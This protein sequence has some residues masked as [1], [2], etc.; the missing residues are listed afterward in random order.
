M[1]DDDYIRKGFVVAACVY[2]SRCTKY[3]NVLILP[4][5]NSHN[6]CTFKLATW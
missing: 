6:Y 5:F 1:P 3:V 2:R 4:I